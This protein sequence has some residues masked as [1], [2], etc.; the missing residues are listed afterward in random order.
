[1]PRALLS[2]SDKTGLTHLAKG[3]RRA[4]FS[5]ISTGGTYKALQAA[6]LDVTQVSQ[7]TGFPEILD[8]RV[9]T[10]HP[11]VHGGIMARG[12][13]EHL[14]QLSE[15][16]IEPIDVVVVNLYPFRETAARAG[17]SFA[18]VVEQIDIGGPAMLRAA[19]KNHE[20]VWVVVEPA[21]YPLLLDSLGTAEERSVR[22]RLARKAFAH[23]AAYDAAITEYLTAVSEEAEGLALSTGD[24]V[25]ESQRALAFD[26]A[27]ESPQDTLPASM[28]L[29]LERR[30]LLR[31]GE[32]PHQQGARYREMGRDSW[33]DDVVLHKGANLSYLNVF[34]AE[35]AWRL[36][37]EFDEP[38]CVI[39][40]H[41]NPCGAA[42]APEIAQAYARAYAADPK[43]AFGGVVAL[44]RQVDEKT[45]EQI[46]ANAKADVLIAP[47]YDE[48]ARALLSAKRKTM[49]VLAAPHPGPREPELRRVGGG[50]LVQEPDL[51][52]RD[53]SEWRVVTQA[54]PSKEQ[55]RDI[56]IA[57]TV[58]A[59][60]SSNAIV[61]V[62]DSA[63]VGVGAGQQ[64][65]VDAAELAAAKAAGR[66]RGG[67]CASDA[68]YPFRDGLDAAARAGVAT[69]IQPGGS[70]RDDELIAAANEHGIAMVFT[71]RRHFKH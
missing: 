56:E 12:T 39:V 18:E 22:T 26:S 16:G 65:R 1:M 14:D 7:L 59:R 36:V 6:G 71:A 24:A 54:A 51:L 10:L 69:V 70:V 66:A 63:A 20:R 45:T 27:S 19:A 25:N 8:G 30:E 23:T 48:K 53:R 46:M 49:R 43:S 35:A 37:F 44:N 2:V 15:H 64:S 60:T 38:A 3:L 55:W 32:N 21:D 33:W 68:F 57:W 67:A 31:Y 17:A 50:F 58:C 52:R 41:A 42:L 47:G 28:V 5:L 9:K 4:G 61:L 62:K 11:A 40:K 29:R 13:R 34:D